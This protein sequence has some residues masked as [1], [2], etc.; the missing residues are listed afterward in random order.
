MFTWVKLWHF[1]FT[2][3]AGFLNR[4]VCSVKMCFTKAWSTDTA[5]WAGFTISSAFI[6]LQ[7]FSSRNV[8]L[9][10]PSPWM[11]LSLLQKMLLTPHVVSVLLQ[12]FRTSGVVN[13]YL[14]SVFQ[15]SF[16]VQL[17]ISYE[18]IMR[19]THLSTCECRSFFKKL[20]A[21]GLHFGQLLPPLF[22]STQTGAIIVS[23]TLTTNG[24]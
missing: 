12:C 13:G 23:I 22:L 14:L 9:Y 3:G 18:K 5:R 11:I 15:T 21:D 24:N 6:P 4:R 20:I 2:A 10:G 19:K 7:L 16:T 17:G 1:S 8:S